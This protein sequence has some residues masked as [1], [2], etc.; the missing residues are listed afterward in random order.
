MLTGV[1]ERAATRSLSAAKS[2]EAPKTRSSMA[3][4]YALTGRRHG[5]IPRRRD[6]R[7]TRDTTAGQPRAHGGERRVEATPARVQ[8]A[9]ANPAASPQPCTGL[10]GGKEHLTRGRPAC[11]T[12]AERA[13]PHADA[14]STRPRQT[15]QSPCRRGTATPP[16]QD[17]CCRCS[18]GYCRWSGA[19]AWRPQ[20][21]RRPGNWRRGLHGV[22][23]GAPT[24]C[25]SAARVNCL[26]WPHSAAAGGAAAMVLLQASTCGQEV[27]GPA[28]LHPLVQ[29]LE[30]SAAEQVLDVVRLGVRH[31]HILR[32]HR[33]G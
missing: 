33:H 7:D 20:G 30:E 1:P 19:H 13:R 29:R 11:R 16:P 15:R 24:C 9:P 6:T 8:G 28:L 32:A 14:P 10:R 12:C 17:P 22:E 26:A 31:R 25:G 18:A 4:R 27:H 21:R 3:S 5:E 2:D 23:G